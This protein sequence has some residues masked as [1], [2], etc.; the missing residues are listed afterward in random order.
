[1]KVYNRQEFLKLPSGTIFCKGAKWFFG[2]ICIKGHSSELEND[3]CYLDL[4]NIESDNSDQRVDRLEDSLING[5]SYEINNSY[6]RDTFFD[7]DD[8]FLVFEKKDL[9]FLSDIIKKLYDCK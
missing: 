2:T 7:D 3:I 5:N 6:G 4:C 1:M 8:L 9:E